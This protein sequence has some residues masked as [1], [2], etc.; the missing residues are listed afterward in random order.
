MGQVANSS[1]LGEQLGDAGLMGLGGKVDFLC[2]H[3]L[4]AGFVGAK[5]LL[6]AGMV[7]GLVFEG[8]IFGADKAE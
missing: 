7:G 8:K 6:Y 4:G 1:G 2:Y 3:G 5:E